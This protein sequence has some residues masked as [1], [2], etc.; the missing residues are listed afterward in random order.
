MRTMSTLL[1]PG[2]F[3]SQPHKGADALHIAYTQDGDISIHSP[4]RGLTVCRVEEAAW[5]YHFNS[6]P[7]K[8]ADAVSVCRIVH[9]VISIHSPT[10][11]LT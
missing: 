9:P 6:Q 2:H 7:H 11:G 1:S 10:R 4:T 3:N 8:G 5:L